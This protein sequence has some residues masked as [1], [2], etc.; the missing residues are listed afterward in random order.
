MIESRS[1]HLPGR[2]VF[3]LQA[4]RLQST[5]YHCTSCIAA[6]CYQEYLVSNPP[7]AALRARPPSWRSG[8]SGLV[9]AG[10][11]WV[12]QLQILGE[13]LLWQVVIT[14]HVHSTHRW[15]FG[16][17]VGTMAFEYISGET[18]AF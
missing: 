9:I 3:P 15:Y 5:L 17:R 4:V 7:T 2:R 16:R 12:A 13:D 14:Q 1:Y 11:V 10:V 6:G 18:M 8:V